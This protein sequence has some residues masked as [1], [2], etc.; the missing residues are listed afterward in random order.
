MVKIVTCDRAEEISASIQTN[1]DG[2]TF[3]N[4]SFKRE[5]QII[6]LQSLHSSVKINTICH[7]KPINTF[8]RLI[9]VIER[10]P[11]NEIE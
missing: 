5:R 11:E 1:L 7:N 8:L 4:I 9:L 2:K 6:T 3:S 10:K